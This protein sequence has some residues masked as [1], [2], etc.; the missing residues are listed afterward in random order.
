MIID[1]HCHIGKDLEGEQYSIDELRTSMSRF[2]IDKSVVFPFCNTDKRMIEESLLLLDISKDDQR[3]IPF[4]RFNPKTIK[5]DELKGLLE[6][7]FRGIKLHP[8]SE[9]FNPNYPKFDWI[10]RM[11]E[12]KSF[13][14]EPV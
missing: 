10:Y 12:Q 7:G 1:F 14:D 2:N 9:R 6:K 13:T 8:K 5:E 4:L 3:I 11:C